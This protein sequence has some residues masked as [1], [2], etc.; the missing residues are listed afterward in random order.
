[1]FSDWVAMPRTEEEIAVDN[2][3][4]R[5]SYDTVTEEEFKAYKQMLR[6]LPIGGQIDYEIRFVSS[7]VGY[8]KTPI[9]EDCVLQKIHCDNC[10]G[11]GRTGTTFWDARNCHTCKQVGWYME[12]RLSDGS[13]PDFGDDDTDDDDYYE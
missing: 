1:M 10:K 8:A 9:E 3:A 11:H 4:F 13:I 6:S 12:V 2:A 7:V 5:A